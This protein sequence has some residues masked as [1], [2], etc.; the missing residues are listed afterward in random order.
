VSHVTVTR[1]VSR[2]KRDGYLQAEPYRPIQLTEKG[3]R[4]AEESRKRHEVVYRFLLALGVSEK[5]AAIDAEGIEHHVSPE[6]LQRFREF[7]EHWAS[8]GKPD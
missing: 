3:A 4:L 8:R 2:L 7:A 5:T 1:I 6:T